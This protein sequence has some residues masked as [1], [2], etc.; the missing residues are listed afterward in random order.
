MKYLS[1]VQSGVDYVEARLDQDIQLA[2]VAAVACMS[3]WHFQRIFKALTNETLKSYIRSRRMAN[4]F[5]RLIHS[6][7]RIIDIAVR[8]GF[9]SQQ[10]FTRAFKKIYAMTPDACRKLGQRNTFPQKVQIDA[11]YLRHINENLTL[12]PTIE[13]RPSMTLVGL[14]TTFYDSSSEKNTIAEQ[15]PSLWDA[16]VPRLDE[17]PGRTDQLAY[18]VIHQENTEGEHLEYLAGVEVAAAESMPSGMV[19]FNVPAARYATFAHRGEPEKLDQTVNYIYSTWLL[20]SGL[21]HSYG[22]DLEIYG[23]DYRPGEPTSVMF[24]AIPLA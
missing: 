23:P 11:A 8:A 18:G 4:A 13:H 20:Q 24:Y 10:S 17:V 5:E 15:L 16:F 2:D 19:P 14:A 9:D 6:D 7:D 21:A 1:H 22:P 3:Q 12:E